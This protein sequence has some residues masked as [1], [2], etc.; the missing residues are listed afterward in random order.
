MS[1]SYVGV[2]IGN[3]V[4]RAAEVV[5]VGKG[6]PQLVR[7]HSMSVPASAIQRGEVLEKGTV[8]AALKQMW[9]AAGFKSKKV[10]L[11]MGN[12]RVLVRDVTVPKAP[13]AQIKESLPFQ[14][15]ELL[16]VPVAD[17]LL[18]F[19]PVSGGV[20]EGGEVINGLLIAAVKEPVLAN[21]EAVEAAGLEPVDVDLVPFALVRALV[22]PE[23]AHGTT[24]IIHLG[25][26][27]STVVV[28]S[29]GVPQFVR[30]IQQGSEDITNA[31]AQGLGIEKNQADQ[32]K[33]GFGLAPA[34]VSP[35]WKP[36]IEMISTTTSGLLESL[37]NTLSFYVNTHK[38]TRIDRVLLSGG[39]AQMNGLPQA[40][41][42]ATR[43]P[44][45]IPDITK[46]FAV[47]K[48][49]SAEALR[50]DLSGLAVAGGL[51]IGLRK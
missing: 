32:V 25:A 29:E 17:A 16:P 30:I 8:S 50:A 38:G 3:G 24:A 36:A 13:L 44:V 26:T 12:H 51:V 49:V 18:D 37:R 39:G 48:T 41:A 35:D 5:D 21:V 14:V 11:G 28:V 7:Y 34:E 46:R 6:R 27:M 1:T 9:S 33:R 42:E 15:Q 40:V 43:L 19:Y 45:G 47:A 31:L 20:G 22:G 2:D 4:I 10:V 23:D